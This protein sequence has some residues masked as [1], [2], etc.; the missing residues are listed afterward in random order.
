LSLQQITQFQLDA[1]RATPATPLSAAPWSSCHF[2]DFWARWGYGDLKTWGFGDE[3]MP[4][5][6]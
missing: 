5:W 4:S 6:R 2:W 1:E 3:Q